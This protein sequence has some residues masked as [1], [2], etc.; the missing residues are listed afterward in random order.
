MGQQEIL[1]FLK[2]EYKK[3]KTKWFTSVQI[4]KATGANTSNPLNKLRKAK[5]VKWKPKTDFHPPGGWKYQHK[6]NK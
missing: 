4:S 5:F 6:V 3:N 1:T 2:K